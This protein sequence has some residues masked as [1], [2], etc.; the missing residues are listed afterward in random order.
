MN[1]WPWRN[2]PRQPLSVVL[3]TRQGCHLC[4][5]AW[6]LLTARQKVHGFELRAV[7][8]ES[9]PELTER[10]GL[11]IPVVEVNG[12]ERLW[13]PINAVLLDRMLRARG[14]QK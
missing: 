13:G 11:R 8:I 7:D 6:D 1:L 5:D 14:E 2:R 9:D 4:D 10:H 3:Y 12:K